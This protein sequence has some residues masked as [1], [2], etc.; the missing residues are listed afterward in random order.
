MLKLW[1]THF[2]MPPSTHFS[3]SN[4]KKASISKQVNTPALLRA[5]RFILDNYKE[6]INLQNIAAYAHWSRYDFV[7]QFSK[8][9]GL[10]PFQY[11]RNLWIEE[12]EKL[13]QSRRVM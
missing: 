10:S 7:R 1:T 12:A 9:Y 8:K 3:V 2:L 6:Q 5:K 11:L 13:F 4:K